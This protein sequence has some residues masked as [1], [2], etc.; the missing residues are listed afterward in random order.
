MHGVLCEGSVDFCYCFIVIP[1][2]ALLK[3][4]SVSVSL[5]TSMS[6]PGVLMRNTSITSLEHVKTSENSLASVSNSKTFPI[7]GSPSVSPVGSTPHTS[8]PVAPCKSAQ[9]S[10]WLSHN[11]TLVGSCGD[12]CM[13]CSNITPANSDSTVNYAITTGCTSPNPSTTAQIP[14]LIPTATLSPKANQLEQQ[15][16]SPSMNT[17]DNTTSL[18]H[19]HTAFHY[20]GGHMLKKPEFVGE[21]TTPVQTELA[22]G[23][24]QEDTTPAI[25][26][27]EESPPNSQAVDCNGINSPK[28][29]GNELLLSTKLADPQLV[30][31]HTSQESVPKTAS[32]T[33][34]LKLVDSKR[35]ESPVLFDTPGCIGGPQSLA[36]KL[37]KLVNSNKQVACDCSDH[38]AD[39]DDDKTPPISPDDKPTEDT[40]LE[41]ERTE[42]DKTNYQLDTTA[43]AQQKE[44]EKM[45]ADNDIPSKRSTTKKGASRQR[46][47]SSALG[48]PRTR[49]VN[50]RMAKRKSIAESSV[51]GS[52]KK[53]ARTTPSKVSVAND[54]DDFVPDKK[55]P[56]KQATVAE[57]MELQVYRYRIE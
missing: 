50:T 4:P 42:L 33:P 39:F 49:R 14:S 25:I 28:I 35:G 18:S 51:C 34:D 19:I 56:R 54:E 44:E 41:C 23:I 31:N 30:P 57:P 17:K 8:T 10:L 43:A 48:Q 11:V 40:G 27:I 26:C 5:G 20:P 3:S 2:S 6:S 36:T 21:S 29:E 46:K 16:R 37:S 53:Y 15:S 45:E 47:G 22:T 52:I 32:N 55:T 1:H 9:E 12:S 24:K 13:P 38:N 7:P